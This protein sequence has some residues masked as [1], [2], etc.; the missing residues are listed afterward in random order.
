MNTVLL[1]YLING[2]VFRKVKTMTKQEM[3]SNNDGI[4]YWIPF[5]GSRVLT[6]V[7]PVCTA[8][9]IHQTASGSFP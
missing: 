2:S 9:Y 3:E 7:S 8:V 6:S 5:M 4:L 1:N